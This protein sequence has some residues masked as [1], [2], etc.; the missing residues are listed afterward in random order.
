MDRSIGGLLFQ[1]SPCLLDFLILPLHLHVTFRELLCFLL[2]LLVRLP[3]LALLSLQ[4]GGQIALA[5]Q[6]IG[7]PGQ[8]RLQ[9]ILFG[10]AV[11]CQPQVIDHR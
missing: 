9:S 5:L 3:Q 4:L 7:K 6:H 11:C 2:Q 10:V 1:C 8:I